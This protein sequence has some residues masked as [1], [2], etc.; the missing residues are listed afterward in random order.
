M[1]WDDDESYAYTT[2]HTIKDWGWE[3][4]RRNPVYKREWKKAL[5]KF[6]NTPINHVLM[7]FLLAPDVSQYSKTDH[8]SYEPI[9][10]TDPTV[11]DTFVIPDDGAMKWG[12]RYYQNPDSKKLAQANFFPVKMLYIGDTSGLETND[13][14]TVAH[15]DHTLIA[16]IDLTRPVTP[17]IEEISKK[18]KEKQEIV[19][20]SESAT[21][22]AKAKNLKREDVFLWLEYLRCLDAR[23]VKM[24]REEIAKV[25][26]IPSGEQEYRDRWNEVLKQSKR[27]L[28][29]GFCRLM[30]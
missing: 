25:F 21:V 1:A 30:A 3:F 18:A 8:L 27:M 11:I 7:P 6:N 15:E 20:E 13:T 16:S 10:L 28:R 19:K 4:I 24:N 5:R 2:S 22:I 14:V 29:E 23:K 9:N 26:L 17:Q 12:L